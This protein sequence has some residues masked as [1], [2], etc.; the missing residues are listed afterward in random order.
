MKKHLL[1]FTMLLL[2]LLGMTQVVLEDF[3][4]GAK[5][6]WNAIEGAYSTVDNPAGGNTLGL[7]SSA[8]VGSYTKKAGS[9]YSLFLPDWPMR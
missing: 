3:E 1:F 5:L 4:G 9:A 2:P 8:K 6:P 7:N